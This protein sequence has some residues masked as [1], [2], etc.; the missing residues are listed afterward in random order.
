MFTAKDWYPYY[1]AFADFFDELDARGYEVV[2]LKSLAHK[3]DSGSERRIRH[4]VFDIA[5]ER[6]QELDFVD[7]FLTLDW[8]P[9]SYDFPER[10]K[11][12][13]FTHYYTSETFVQQ[14]NNCC[15]IYD[16]DFIDYHFVSAPIDVTVMDEMRSIAKNQ[17][18]KFFPARML[19]KRCCVIPGGYPKLD[20]YS[21]Y[22]RQV[23]E[24][25]HDANK[26]LL[27]AVTGIVNG[28]KT[29]P[30]HGRAIIEALLTNFPEYQIAFRPTPMD[31]NH[32]IV[33]EIIRE[34]AVRNQFRVDMSDD[35]K[36]SYATSDLMICDQTNART[37][38]AYSTLRPYIR[39]C[40]E[41]SQSHTTETCL[42]VSARDIESLV[43]NAKSI[44]TSTDDFSERILR[45]RDSRVANCGYSLKYL[46]DN[47]DCILNGQP[48]P[49]WFYYDRSEA[50]AREPESASEYLPYI[51]FYAQTSINYIQWSWR[52]CRHALQIHPNAS[53]LHIVDAKILFLMEKDEQAIDA[54]NA[55]FALDKDLAG[56]LFWGEPASPPS[57]QS[58]RNH[59]KSAL[60]LFASRFLTKSQRWFCRSSPKQIADS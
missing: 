57:Q 17:P 36:H 3:I 27:F 4:D 55:A 33:L 51:N 24:T 10:S 43:E 7:I 31:R 48:H 26:R 34:F 2:I 5:P 21:R 15:S 28:D 14:L 54:R 23:S 39:C 41:P 9:Y 19:T 53:S 44:L 45:D 18:G 38:F 52:I 30:T 6:L 25:R 20:V 49:D 16:G 8:N 11:V 58:I 50:N 32:P 46:A 40:F 13:A 12:V 37:T 29:L 35:I 60:R 42:G 1:E 22:C 56:R 59:L 47:L